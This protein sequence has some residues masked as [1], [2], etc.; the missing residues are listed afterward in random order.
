[1]ELVYL[2]GAEAEQYSE[3]LRAALVEAGWDVKVEA[4]IAGGVIG[5]RVMSGDDPTPANALLRALQAAGVALSRPP[6]IK[7]PNPGEIPVGSVKLEVGSR[8]L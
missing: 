5:V 7:N 8:P 1:V 4:A 3:Q 2:G 6:L